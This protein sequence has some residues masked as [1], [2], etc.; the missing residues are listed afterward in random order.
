MQTYN[1]HSDNTIKAEIVTDFLCAAFE[2]NAWRTRHSLWGCDNRNF[3]IGSTRHMGLLLPKLSVTN[4]GK[5][6][7]I[8]NVNK[9]CL[10]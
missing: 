2:T 6:K 3:A 1:K 4:P 7:K 9:I 5:T 10:L 8:P